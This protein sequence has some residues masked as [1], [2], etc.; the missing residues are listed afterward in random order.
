MGAAI[1]SRDT[2][3]EQVRALMLRK[4]GIE[5][6]LEAQ[7]TILNAH[8]CTMQTPL[9]D[10]E[11]FPRADIDIYA[12]RHARVRI[13]ELRNDHKAV[14]DDIL[15]GLQGVYNPDLVLNTPATADVAANASGLQPF[16]RVDGVAPGSPAA[17]AG[18]IRE[19]LI[20]AFGSLTRASFSSNS[21]Q[22]LATLVAT[23]ENQEIS[24]KVL[25]SGQE[26][27]ELTFVPRKGWGGRGLLGCHIVPHST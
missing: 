2:A 4:E 21:L 27:V 14:M 18:L 24:V 5:A 17:T 9:V 16:A 26:I 7:F 13:I 23:Q 15:K 22:P 1:P 8:N 12:V 6:E 19:D 25:R 20:L 11:G 10:E 3:A